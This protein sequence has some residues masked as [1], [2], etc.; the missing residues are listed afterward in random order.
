MLNNVYIEEMIN[1][2]DNLRYMDFCRLLLI[3]YWNL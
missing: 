2:A 1:G 3:I